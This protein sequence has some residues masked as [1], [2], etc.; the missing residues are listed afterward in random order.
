MR[1][2][3]S[4]GDSARSHDAPLSRIR[5][6]VVG[7]GCQRPREL[8]AQLVRTVRQ[9]LEILQSRF[10]TQELI[11]ANMRCDPFLQFRSPQR[12]CVHP[13]YGS[14]HIVLIA[15]VSLSVS[16]RLLTLICLRVSTAAK[17][18]SSIQ[19]RFRAMRRRWGPGKRREK[20][21]WN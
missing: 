6:S 12:V 3:L 1:G 2:G 4:G 8:I 14:R 21:V 19:S 11:M 13:A 18:V 16:Q 5:E 9:C 7:R 17:D 15:H 10:L 20:P